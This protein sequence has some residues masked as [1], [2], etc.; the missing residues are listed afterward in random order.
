MIFNF[1]KFYQLQAN[2][3]HHLDEKKWHA[4]YFWKKN[5]VWPLGDTR[6]QSLIEF[7][8]ALIS[9]LW[10]CSRSFQVLKATLKH[11]WSKYIVCEG[12]TKHFLFQHYTK[13]SPKITPKI[14]VF[15]KTIFSYVTMHHYLCLLLS[16]NS[17]SVP[18]SFKVLKSLF[19]TRVNS[20]M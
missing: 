2:F 16:Q 1:F 10:F 17:A 11:L 20:G 12:A 18:K 7:F 15:G 6:G 14:H 19:Q 4:K 3:S 5:D 9:I 13:K 8:T